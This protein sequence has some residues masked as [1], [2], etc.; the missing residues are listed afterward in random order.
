[1]TLNKLNYIASPSIALPHI[2]I[3]IK[4][5]HYITYQLLHHITKHNN[6]QQ[7]TVKILKKS[8]YIW[9]I[10]NTNIGYQ[11]CMDSPP[12]AR[13]DYLELD[14]VHGTNELVEAAAD[15]KMLLNWKT[16]HKKGFHDQAVWAQKEVAQSSCLGTKRVCTLRDQA[17]WAQERVC[18]IEISGRKKSLHDQAF[19]AQKKFARSL[20]LG[21]QESLHDQAFWAPQGFAWSRL[22]G[23]KRVYMIKL[24]GRQRG[25]QDKTFLTQTE[26]APSNFLR[27]Q[28]EIP[29]SSFLGAKRLCMLKLSGHTKVC[30]S[31][32]LRRKGICTIKLFGSKREFAWSRLWSKKNT[33]AA[34]SRFVNQ[35]RD[36]ATRI[37]MIHGQAFGHQRWCCVLRGRLPPPMTM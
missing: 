15:G 19:W 32:L 14:C 35:K 16:F 36:C 7:C 20:L 5:L 31:K 8:L 28:K 27:A 23:V 10:L 1:M 22:L 13:W 6:T 34:W 4:S 37:C 12:E 17:F 3:H 11:G 9:Y 24:Y 2:T 29:W 33:H 30:M 25:L 18:M 21:K 26:F